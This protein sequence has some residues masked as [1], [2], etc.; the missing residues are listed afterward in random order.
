[1]DK[2][3]SVGWIILLTLVL[4]VIV[5]VVILFVQSKPD[6]EPVGNLTVNKTYFDIYVHSSALTPITYALSNDSALLIKG[7]LHDPSVIEEYHGVEANST[8]QLFGWSDEY[9]TNM[10]LC[11]VSINKTHCFLSL[12]R[13]AKNYQLYLSEQSLTVY[14]VDGVIQ[15]PIIC[16]SWH[17]NV[18]NV[19]M[20]L[21]YVLVPDDMRKYFDEC[22]QSTNMYGN[23]LLPIV[24][25]RNVAFTDP[26]N[27]SVFVLDFER[28]GYNPIGWRNTTVLIS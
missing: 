26:G 22:F 9:Y 21:P 18:A 5:V 10:T 19:L 12:D 7:T 14:N 3:G 13:K 1:M 4:I 28:H 15:N 24:V 11:N 27:L 20:D 17:T 2:R 25:R 16:F 23:N 8:L 6:V